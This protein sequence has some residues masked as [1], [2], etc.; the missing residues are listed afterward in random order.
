VTCVLVGMAGLALAASAGVALADPG[1]NGAPGRSEGER[2]GRAVSAAVAVAVGN[3]GKDG[4]PGQD[5]APGRDGAPGE[6]GARG[7]RMEGERS[8]RA[9]RAFK[10]V[11]DDGRCKFERKLEKSGEYKEEIKCRPGGRN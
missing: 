5:G 6:N 10:E 2:S 1:T 3:P 4:A 8:P 7:G 11:Y 9:V